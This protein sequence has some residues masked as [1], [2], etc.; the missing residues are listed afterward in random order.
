MKTAIEVLAYMVI[1]TSAP[2]EELTAMFDALP[3]EERAKIKAA[4]AKVKGER[5]G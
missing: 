2:F 1:N 4:F 3:K 5:K